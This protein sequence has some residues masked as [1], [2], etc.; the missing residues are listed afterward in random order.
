[1]DETRLLGIKFDNHYARG[2]EAEEV[3]KAVLAADWSAEPEMAAAARLL[4]GWDFGTDATSRTAA[5]GSLTTTRAITQKY[6]GIKA[7]PPETAF[8][9]A[10]AWLKQHHGRIDPEWGEVNRLVRGTVSLPISGAPDTLRAVYPK[11]IRE[12]GELHMSAGDTWIAL[13]EWDAEGRQAAKVIS[14]YGSAVL[15]AASPHFADQAPIFAAQDWRT[16]LLN[17]EDVEAD[18]SRRYRPGKD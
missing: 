12:D 2:S 8:R 9:E 18:A 11:E 16:A 6:S 15:D 5:L 10:V 13:V 14:P 7:P 17:W 4:A 3:V 1:M